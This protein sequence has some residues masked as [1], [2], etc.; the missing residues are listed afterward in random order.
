MNTNAIELKTVQ[1]EGESKKSPSKLLLIIAIICF[2]Y[3]FIPEPSDIIPVFGWL[4]EI[5]AGGVGTTA[6]IAYILKNVIAKRI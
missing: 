4:D 2:V 1:T 6:F 3:I 5:L